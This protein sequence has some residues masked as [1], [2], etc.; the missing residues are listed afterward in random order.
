MMSV[1]VAPSTSV[2]LRQ[3][4]PAWKVHKQRAGSS[5]TIPS[6]RGGGGGR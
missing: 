5:S 3:T 1:D 6:N 4:L 2:A